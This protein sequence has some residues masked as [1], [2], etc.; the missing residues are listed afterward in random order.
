MIQDDSCYGE[1]RNKLMN[2]VTLARILP[3]LK[4]SIKFRYTLY[5]AALCPENACTDSEKIFLK[6]NN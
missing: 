1:Q 4:K 2:S 5:L 6:S 3:S